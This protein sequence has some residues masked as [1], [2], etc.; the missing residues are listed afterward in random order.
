MSSLRGDV[1][2]PPEEVSSPLLTSAPCPQYR[3]SEGGEGF[4]KKPIARVSGAVGAALCKALRGGAVGQ[5][6][7]SWRSRGAHLADVL[8]RGCG[9]EPTGAGAALVREKRELWWVLV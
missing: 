6:L 1:V 5:R 3:A 2:V 4:R 8:L 9:V 7:L